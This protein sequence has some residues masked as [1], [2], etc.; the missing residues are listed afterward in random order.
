MK[1]VSAACERNKDPILAV[2]RRAFSDSQR[3]LEIGSGTG[4]HA[5]HF[6]QALPHLIWQT[7]D[8]PDYHESIL[9]Y[10]AESPAKNIRPPIV[11]DTGRPDLIRNVRAA[12]VS[13]GASVDAVFSA[14]TVQI[15][16][17][18]DIEGMFALLADLLPV[19]GVFCLYAP[20]KY[21][22]EH[23]SQG[24]ADFDASLRARDPGMGV[25]D[26]VWLDGL[27]R[28]AGLQLSTDHA[29]PANNRML[30]YRMIR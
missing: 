24:N 29:M 14:N 13:S 26:F 19:G 12:P 16:G 30:E 21:N 28:A 11:L 7:S 9:A 6:A 5:V 4:Q 2:L 15:M 27:A 3:V 25:R 10:I 18:A 1:R 23:L 8:L 20:L 22:G 17:E